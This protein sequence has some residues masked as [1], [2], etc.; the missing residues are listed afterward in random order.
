MR[1][2]EADRR[3][4]GIDYASRQN[5]QELSGLISQIRE[6]R[7]ILFGYENEVTIPIVAA[8]MQTEIHCMIMA[9]IRDTRLRNA[10][11]SYHDWFA[12]WFAPNNAKSLP[13]KCL[14]LNSKLTTIAA[15]RDKNKEIFLKWNCIEVQFRDYKMFGA[16][17]TVH[18]KKEAKS[19]LDALHAAAREYNKAGAEVPESFFAVTKL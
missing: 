10:L 13:Q 16:R 2:Y 8:G 15:Q 6:A 14:E 12:N 9:G 7:D 17:R 4:H 1:T 19:D 11:V 5:L 3:L 18:E